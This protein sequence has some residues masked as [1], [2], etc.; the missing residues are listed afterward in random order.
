M[1]P[2]LPT[3]SEIAEDLYAVGTTKSMGYLP[4]ETIRQCIGRAPVCVQQELERRGCRAAMFTCDECGVHTGAL[5]AW[6]PPMLER[7]VSD[8][9]ALLRNASWPLDSD[10]FAHAV[11]TTLI[12]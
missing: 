3:A 6:H 11:A 12:S 4:L 1:Q 7:L 9:E 2:V 10:G 5:Y 8:N